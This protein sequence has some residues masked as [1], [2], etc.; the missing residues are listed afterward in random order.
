MRTVSFL[1][2]ARTRT[3]YV[4]SRFAVMSLRDVA[5]S[6]WVGY[7][8]LENGQSHDYRIFLHEFAAFHLSKV[9]PGC[10]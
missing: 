2:L 5:R 9:F 1:S 3:T 10:F 8:I 4:K 7:S 6:G